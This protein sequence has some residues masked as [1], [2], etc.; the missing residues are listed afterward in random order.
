MLTRRRFTLALAGISLALAALAAGAFLHSLAPSD[1]AINDA[2]F[3]V[4]LEPIVEGELQV[5]RVNE[6]PLFVL[7]PNA[8]QR[9][10]IAAMDPYV[11]DK[12]H[13]Y[14]SSEL[15]AYVY[16]GVST[17]WGCPLSEKT[18]EDRQSLWP[19]SPNLWRGGY[20]DGR[21]E[22]SYDYAGRT[23]ADPT[24]SFNGYAV[25]WPN[26]SSP[27]IHATGLLLTVSRL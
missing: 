10:S 1:R 22:V 19:E 7:R 26:L 14:Y 3:V 11:F 18:A 6:S 2:E 9:E 16:W 15:N 24:R 13:G 23:V 21:C 27:R 5:V 20:W 12:T 25:R 4:R 17:K 8:K